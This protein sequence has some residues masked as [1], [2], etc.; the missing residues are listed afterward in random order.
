MPRKHVRKTTEQ[1]DADNYLIDE[2]LSKKIIKTCKNPN[3]SKDTPFYRCLACDNQPCSKWHMIEHLHTRNHPHNQ[4]IYEKS[5]YCA[6]AP[7]PQD[8]E[9]QSKIEKS[10]SERIIND[11]ICKKNLEKDRADKL[12]MRVNKLEE[13][14]QGV[15]ENRDNEIAS[16]QNAIKCLS[17]NW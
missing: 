3:G 9:I 15:R 12:Q 2:L 7:T 8:I 11:L 17:S 16:L 14:L 1:N 10:D 13:E 4:R 6:P 5:K